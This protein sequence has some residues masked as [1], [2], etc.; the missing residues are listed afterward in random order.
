M[1]PVSER[2]RNEEMFQLEQ[3]NISLESLIVNTLSVGLARSSV[4][5]IL[6]R[7]LLP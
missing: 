4:G 3:H 1:M 6:V 5:F 2:N 7:F